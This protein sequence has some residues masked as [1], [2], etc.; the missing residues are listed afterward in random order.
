MAHGGVSGPSASVQ[1]RPPV[2]AAAV[3]ALG[4]DAAAACPHPLDAGTGR[5]GELGG[6]PAPREAF[7]GQS[8]TRRLQLKD[9]SSIIHSSGWNKVAPPTP[10]ETTSRQTPE[11]DTSGSTVSEYATYST[12]PSKT[13]EDAKEQMEEIPDL[14]VMKYN[15]T[16]KEF[17]TNDVMTSITLAQ[18]TILELL[19]TLDI[20]TLA[21]R[22][23]IE[24]TWRMG[25][26]TVKDENV[27]KDQHQNVWS[28][29][30]MAHI[31]NKDQLGNYACIFKTEKKAE[32]RFDVRVPKTEGKSKS[33]ISYV[34]DSVVMSCNSGKYVPSDWVWYT[35]NGSEKVIINDT[36]RPEKYEVFPKNRNITKLKVL[37]INQK[38]GGSYW[39]EAVFLQ[40]GESTG[41]SSLK[42]LTY[43]EPLKL[44]LA[45]AAEVI[46]LVAFIFIYEIYTKKKEPIA[47]GEKE[48]EQTEQLKSEDSNGVEN[49]TTRHRKV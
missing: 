34:G 2:P 19:C 28:S 14:E 4:P 35:K 10:S 16:I 25:N 31:K 1:A 44:F 33:I 17:S 11:S 13:T 40:L 43:M 5:S 32:G 49:S 24:V 3:A 15:I 12:G 48:F 26:T 18:P 42:V 27:T 46:I 36:L 9:P 22:A 39:C 8:S 30:Y 6:V 47:E 29:Q 38:D 37:D 41:N 21:E 20:K 23:T 45:I 7:P